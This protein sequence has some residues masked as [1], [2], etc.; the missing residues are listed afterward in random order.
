MI[1]IYIRN[2]LNIYNKYNSKYTSDIFESIFINKIM[3]R[4]IKIYSCI[5]IKVF[6]EHVFEIETWILDWE[7]KNR[8]Q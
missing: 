5:R 3:N 1:Y 8:K 6:T 7:F 4:L 2:Y